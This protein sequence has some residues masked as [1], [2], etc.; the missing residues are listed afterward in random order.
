MMSHE[1]YTS[2]VF[3]GLMV[4]LLFHLKSLLHLPNDSALMLPLSHDEL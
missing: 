4:V 2:V 1:L 3:I